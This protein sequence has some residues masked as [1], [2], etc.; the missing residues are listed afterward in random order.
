VRGFADGA[1]Q[2]LSVLRRASVILW[3]DSGSAQHDIKV[4]VLLQK[5]HP[6]HD[7]NVRFHLSA[8]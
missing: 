3:I 4:E 6:L 8:G 2:G 5:E 7:C 1:L